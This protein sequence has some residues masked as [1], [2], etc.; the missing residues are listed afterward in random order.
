MAA[1]CVPL[2]V[3]VIVTDVSTLTG[4]VV[5]LKLANPRPAGTVTVAGVCAAAVLLLVNETTAPPAGAALFR[6][7]VVLIEF[8]PVAPLTLG[9][10]DSSDNGAFGSAATESQAVLLAPPAVPVIET[11]VNELTAFVVTVK[12]AVLFP[13]GIVTL[14]GAWATDVSL[15]VSVTIMPPGGA[16]TVK[17]TVP[18]DVFRPITFIGLRP[19]A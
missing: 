14:A 18:R 11:D 12:L 13:A 19:I 5:M 15:L 1:V 2:S 17:P 3:P 6:K 8:P 7:T 9:V 4:E 10:T 16:G